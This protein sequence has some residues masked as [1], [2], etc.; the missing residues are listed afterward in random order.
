MGKVKPRVRLRNE[1]VESE[2]VPTWTPVA[3]PT[4]I[5]MGDYP[6][7]LGVWVLF[8]VCGEIRPGMHIKDSFGDA[9]FVSHSDLKRQTPAPMVPVALPRGAFSHWRYFPK[10]M[11]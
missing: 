9:A 4:W 6:P 2:A 11:P 7:P 10:E 3:P 5:P 8:L 1:K